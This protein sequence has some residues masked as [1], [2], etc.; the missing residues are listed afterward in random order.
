MITS[1]LQRP[2]VG[3]GVILIREGKILLGKRKNAHGHG[4]WSFP[5]GHLEWN[6]SIAQC[7]RREVREETGLINLT[8]LQY[9]PYTNDIFVHEHKHYITIFVVANSTKGDPQVMEPEKCETWQWIEWEH[10][11]EPVFLP[12]L[13]LRKQHFSPLHWQG[14]PLEDEDTQS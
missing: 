10:F 6:E 2:K 3:V 5:G 8:N 13:N 7:A 12:I 11:P 14:R 9:G 4:S 1:E